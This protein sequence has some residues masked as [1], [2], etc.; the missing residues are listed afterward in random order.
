L[1]V[2]GFQSLT[3]SLVDAMEMGG[4]ADAIEAAALVVEVDLV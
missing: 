4:L 2:A 1:E 3:G